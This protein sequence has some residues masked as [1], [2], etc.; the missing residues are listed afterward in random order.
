MKTRSPV[1]AL[2]HH[3]MTMHGVAVHLERLAEKV[4]R[5]PPG[6]VTIDADTHM[7]VLHGPERLVRELIRTKLASP[8]D[9]DEEDE[10]WA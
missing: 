8:C 9:W 5:C 3:A 10:A 1:E 6:S 2:E 4:G 7:I